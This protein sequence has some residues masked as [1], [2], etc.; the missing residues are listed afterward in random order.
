[1]ELVFTTTGGMGGWERK[2]LLLIGNLLSF[3]LNEIP[4]LIVTHGHGFSA[5]S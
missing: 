1:V 4:Y 5:A 3:S 2:Q